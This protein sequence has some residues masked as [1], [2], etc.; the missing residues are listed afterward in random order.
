MP[1]IEYRLTRPETETFIQ[2]RADCGWGLLEK[3]QAE[4]AL[5]NCLYAVTAYHG[6]EIAG[7][8]RVVGDHALNYYVQDLVV[9][10]AYRRRKIGATIMAM[11]IAEIKAN[12]VGGSYAIGLMSAVGKEAFYK[13]FGFVERPSA[14]FGAGMILAVD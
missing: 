4:L 3:R 9:K 11:L 12:A 6:D 7:F 14:A 8:G 2:L 13:Q 1:S 10:P 5:A